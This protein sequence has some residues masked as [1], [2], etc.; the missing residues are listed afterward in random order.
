MKNN[1][2]WS[3]KIAAL[4][5]TL[6]LL[7]SLCAC[8]KEEPHQHAFGEWRVSKAATCG[9]DG[10]S[11][12]ECS[13]GEQETEIIPATRKHKYVSQVT[14]QPTYAEAGV[15]TY[16]CSV[17]GDSYTETISKLKSDW[18]VKN[19]SNDPSDAY[20]V[21]EF[22]GLYSDNGTISNDLTALVFLDKGT[23]DVK[24][25]L[26]RAGNYQVKM[27]NY[28]K[29]YWESY[30]L[31]DGQEKSTKITYSGGYFIGNQE[32]KD[33]ILKNGRI[34]IC[35]EVKSSSYYYIYAFTTTE[36]GL[37]ELYDLT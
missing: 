15:T 25:K 8:K 34:S 20:V 11:V 18:E 4:V 6:A 22:N 17:C 7:V 28:E 21:G 14:K 29:I 3:N 37:K 32:L 27:S 24:I 16:T 1:S 33:A 23:K 12:R 30:T 13:C 2:L 26:L 9:E 19:Y 10:V 5:L 35:F 31:P 36:E